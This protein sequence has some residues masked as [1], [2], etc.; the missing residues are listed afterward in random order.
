M[1]YGHGV[2]AI[3]KFIKKHIPVN[4]T[5]A[6]EHVNDVERSIRTIKD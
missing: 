6:R 4:T 2:Q 1:S 5:V 3:G